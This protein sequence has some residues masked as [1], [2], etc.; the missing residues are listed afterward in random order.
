[1]NMNKIGKSLKLHRI[2]RSLTQRQLASQ[3]NI[4]R[5]SLSLYETGARTPDIYML[6]KIADI[7]DITV[8]ELIGRI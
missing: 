1:M 2:N 5:Q 8:D 3:L 7:Y 4:T 6:S